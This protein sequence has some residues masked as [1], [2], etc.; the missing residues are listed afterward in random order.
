MSFVYPKVDTRTLVVGPSG[1]GKTYF[2]KH[3]IAKWLINNQIEKIYVHN[4]NKG[5]YSFVNKKLGVVNP[6]WTPL[7]GTSRV[8]HVYEN[9][10]QY[11]ALKDKMT[12]IVVSTSL[13]TKDCFDNVVIFG[14]VNKETMHAIYDSFM[15]EIYSFENVCDFIQKATADKYSYAFISMKE[16]DK[17]RV[18][19]V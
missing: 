3:T 16:E 17:Y 10:S 14:P 5:E 4:D 18:S 11:K 19:R 15:N 1:S 13:I 9:D 8:V 2:V 12:N 7:I 6:I